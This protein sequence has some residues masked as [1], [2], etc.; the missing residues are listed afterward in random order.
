MLS[1]LCGLG[2]IVFSCR[3]PTSILIEARTNVVFRPGYTT[4][5]TVGAPGGVESADP[6]TVS[7]A[8]WAADG[9]IGSL[10]TIP[11]S[12]DSALVSLK[13]VLGVRRDSREC[14]APRLRRVHR[15]TPA[16]PLRRARATATPRHPLREL[17]GCAV[18][19]GLDMQPAWAVRLIA[20]RS[21][22]L[23]HALRVPGPRGSN[24]V[25]P[26]PG[27]P[28]ARQRWRRGRDRRCGRW[29]IRL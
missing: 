9:F 2:A 16:P 15:H 22:D 13:V 18:R 6:T 4:T 14:K 8:P 3:E 21:K 5:F 1:L 25:A 10:T 11:S 7:D 28:P 17:R 12:G 24:D 19:R 27:C 20:R 23:R 26:R 29:R